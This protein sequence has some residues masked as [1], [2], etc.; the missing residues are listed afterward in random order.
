LPL[1]IT[2]L[3]VPPKLPNG[4]QTFLA[5]QR[6]FHSEALRDSMQEYAATREQLFRTIE[7]R[8]SQL[9]IEAAWLALVWCHTDVRRHLA[10]LPPVLGAQ[11]DALKAALAEGET[12]IQK[13]L[14]DF[15]QPEFLPAQYQTQ[16]SVRATNAKE[17][18]MALRLDQDSVLPKLSKD[19]FPDPDK[20]STAERSLLNAIKSYNDARGTL[21]FNIAANTASTS[22]ED[23]WI[24]LAFNHFA[25]KTAMENAGL[26]P[27]VKESL[28]KGLAAGQEKI[29]KYISAIE[30]VERLP[31]QLRNLRRQRD[32]QQP[33]VQAPRRKNM[34]D[35][36]RLFAKRS[37]S[38]DVPAT[39]EGHPLSKLRSAMRSL[40]DLTQKSIRS[41]EPLPSTA[42][43]VNS[44]LDAPRQAP[45]AHQS[46]AEPIS[47]SRIM[48]GEAI[49]PSFRPPTD[50]SQSAHRPPVP[51]TNQKRMRRAPR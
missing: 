14:P 40:K 10:T 16:R 2:T 3:Q 46:P 1:D 5:D 39:P 42:D 9:E 35:L 24:H 19:I 36:R 20:L 29:E 15:D 21:S 45:G 32:I 22:I 50:L 7:K 17:K 18:Q 26:E 48:R 51:N 11:A 34:S 37:R 33:A 27:G 23:S 4:D 13:T 12:R 44:M 28:E 31:S 8:M 49:P 25:V 38:S 41:P 47:Q 43:I 6:S 30:S